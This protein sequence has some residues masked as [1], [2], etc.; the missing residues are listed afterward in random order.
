MNKFS[1]VDALVGDLPAKLKELARELYH[2]G[3]L[4]EP[5]VEGV[6]QL[7]LA[8]GIQAMWKNLD[9]KEDAR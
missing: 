6:A 7:A 4:N 8:V 1:D 5:N 2:Q 3:M 9:E